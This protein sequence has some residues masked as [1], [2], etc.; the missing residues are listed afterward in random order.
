MPSVV[1]HRLHQIIDAPSYEPPHTYGSSG[2]RLKQPVPPISAENTAG[3]CQRGAH[4]QTMSPR[5]PTTAP[6]SPSATSEYSRR[7]WGWWH[8]DV[9]VPR[10]L[11]GASSR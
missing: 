3:S 10:E 5:G 8:E 6:R 1:T 4:N 9:P 2:A 7:T 11:T